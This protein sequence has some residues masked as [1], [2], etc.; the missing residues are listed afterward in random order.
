MMSICIILLLCLVSLTASAVGWA[1]G[2]TRDLIVDNRVH[3]VTVA[4]PDDPY[5]PPV[6]VL[7]SDQRL[8]V[9]FDVL[10]YD[11]EY[12]RYSVYHCDALWRPTATLVESEWVDGFNY[13]DIDEWEQ[14]E[15]TF[16]SF[17]TY[18]FMLPNDDFK[19]TRSGNYV[20][21][22]YEQ[23]D[24]GH[25][26][27]QRRFSVCENIV[28]VVCEV[29][30]STDV[31]YNDEHQQ[32]SY[33]ITY[34]PGV[35]SDAYNDLTS[36]I[37]QNNR[38]ASAVVVKSP[39]MVAPGKVTYEHRSELIFSATNEYRRFEIVNSHGMNMGVER[40]QYFEPFYHVTLNRDEPRRYT[41][42]LYDKTQM[43][44]F[45]IRNAEYS[46]DEA[47]CASDYV[48]THFTLDTG[49]PVTG[50][51]VILDGELTRGLPASSRVMHYDA[52]TGC[53]E[54]QLL[55]KQG[56]YNYQYAFVPDGTTVPRYD[57]IDGNKYQTTNEYLVKVYY[58]PS[59][60]RYDRFVGFGIIHSGI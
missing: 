32:L 55:L 17:Y 29:T 10:D 23:D 3:T 50:G 26:L 38:D 47:D 54:V 15:A 42:Y 27:L 60:E 44:H 9:K 14:N 18:R 30:T 19:I 36:V 1:D 20:V 35:V 16:T 43:G 13:G 57:L 2:D 40:W 33:D 46:W 8:E 51:N 37:T 41:Q 25:V 52:S 22:V 48:W 24:P 56:A 28:N 39:T 58:R 12:L 11:V 4:P 45:T 5:F 7:D 6:M 59:G 31:D 49:G 21:V 34:R 53:Y